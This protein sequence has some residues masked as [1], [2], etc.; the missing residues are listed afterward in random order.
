MKKVVGEND[1]VPILLTQEQIDLIIEHTFA[2]DSLLNPLRISEVVGL[3]MYE[4]R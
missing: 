4:L 2:E 1:K 3:F